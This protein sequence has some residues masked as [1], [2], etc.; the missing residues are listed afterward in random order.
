MY[1]IQLARQTFPDLDTFFEDLNREIS[2]KR[3]RLP[4]KLQQNIGLMISI[5]SFKNRNDNLIASKK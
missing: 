1:V 2:G 3:G 4:P 5:T